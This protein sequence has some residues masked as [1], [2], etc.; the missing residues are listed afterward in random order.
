[1][2][3]VSPSPG[4]WESV[5]TEFVALVAAFALLGVLVLADVAPVSFPVPVVVAS[6]VTCVCLVVFDA[7][8]WVEVTT[9]EQ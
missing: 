3:P 2:V 5:E 6:L 7:S 4:D 1:M 9:S 8:V